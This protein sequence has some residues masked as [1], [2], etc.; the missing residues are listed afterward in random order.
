MILDL[1]KAMIN[2]QKGDPDKIQIKKQKNAMGCALETARA[3]AKGFGNKHPENSD[4]L[5]REM[6]ENKKR[7]KFSDK[8]Q[9]NKKE[10]GI[11]LPEATKKFGIK[12]YPAGKW[13][14][15]T[16]E[17]SPVTASSLK[18]VQNKGNIGVVKASSGPIEHV[19]PVNYDQKQKKLK[20]FNSAGKS[21]SVPLKGKLPD[22]FNVGGDTFMHPQ[23]WAAKKK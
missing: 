13:N 19:M 21:S 22:S 2:K 4:K 11:P 14:S 18:K 10:S 20:F 3:L 12:M 9:G 5:L 6:N 23:L 7:N 16:T 15:N 1:N 17:L 8:W